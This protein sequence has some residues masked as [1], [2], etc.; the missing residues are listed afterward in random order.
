MQNRVENT[1]KNFQENNILSDEDLLFLIDS[2]EE[3]EKAVS[4]CDTCFHGILMDILMRLQTL[5]NIQKK[6]DNKS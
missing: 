6:R 1:W 2:Y 3:L 4:N 5:K